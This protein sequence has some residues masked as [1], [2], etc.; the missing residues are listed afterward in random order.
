MF[1]DKYGG[2]TGYEVVG[3]VWLQ[4]FND[5]VENQGAF[6]P[7]YDH[8]LVDLVNDI[9]AADSRIPGLLPVVVAESSDQNEDLNAE[10][11][12]GVDAINRAN[13]GTAVFIETNGLIGVNYGGPNPEGN[14]FSDVAAYH[15]HARP[16]N[17]LE[18][19]YRIGTAILDNGFTGTEDVPE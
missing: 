19:G 5:S 4:G 2:A 12:A 6:I 18:I 17:Y 13:A 1:D 14:P 10:R 8:N 7:E 11:R 9:R 16:E 3:L 15:F